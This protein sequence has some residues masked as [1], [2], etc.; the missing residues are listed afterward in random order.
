MFKT[1]QEIIQSQK[2]LAI[3]LLND[4]KDWTG[5]RAVVAGG[6]PRDWTIGY[7]AD[8]IDIYVESNSKIGHKRFMQELEEMLAESS[9]AFT[10]PKQVGA[11]S[12]EDSS[13]DVYDALDYNII[14]VYEFA[15]TDLEVINGGFASQRVQIIRIEGDPQ[16]VFTHFP[17]TTSQ[18]MMKSDGVMLHTS[19]FITAIQTKTARWN[20]LVT[21]AYLAKMLRKSSLSNF[22]FKRGF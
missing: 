15:I 13:Y 4:I 8:D 17:V 22:S 5:K 1:T 10:R 2:I 16:D 21:D 3:Q 6:A 7:E 11:Y 9:Y 19:H 18:V 14:G 12:T 20:G